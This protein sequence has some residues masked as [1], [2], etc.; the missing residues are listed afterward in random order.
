M[1]FGQTGLLDQT[2]RKKK[3]VLYDTRK[4]K[5]N[6]ESFYPGRLE[7]MDGLWRWVYI[8]HRTPGQ[9][10]N[11]EQ[12]VVATMSCISN[13]ADSL[14]T[15]NGAWEVNTSAAIEG[16]GPTLYDLV[17]SISPGGLYS[18]RT[19]VSGEAH[20]VWEFYANNRPDI[21]KKIM[22]GSN[23]TPDDGSDD[24]YTHDDHNE[25]MAIATRLRTREFMKKYAADAG[26]FGMVDVF[27]DDV[28]YDRDGRSI[29]DTYGENLF[30]AFRSWFRQEIRPDTVEMENKWLEWKKSHPVMNYVKWQ[31]TDPGYLDIIYNTDYALGSAQKMITNHEKMLED[32]RNLGINYGSEDAVNRGFAKITKEFF[33]EYYMG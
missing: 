31:I 6:I 27:Y 5:K 23:L 2:K 12:A 7:A 4:A 24:C 13:P 1:V 18:D 3:F 28:K 17:M 32:L 20:G 29:N 16:H 11:M 9:W 26:S 30:R 25:M 33:D 14:Y 8:S 19:S 21:E 10:K 22:D 15:C